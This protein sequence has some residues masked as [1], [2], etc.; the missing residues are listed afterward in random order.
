MPDYVP[1]TTPGA[2]PVQPV[3]PVPVPVAAGTPVVPVQPVAVQQPVVVEQPP[4]S[5]LYLHIVSHSNLFY[6]WPVWAVGY[7]MALLTW[8]HGEKHTI[9]G[10]PEL[11]NANSDLGVIFFLTLLFVI[12]VTNVS[13][14]GLVS[15]LVVTALIL[16][17][18]LLAWFGWWDTVLSWFGHLKVHLNL[19]AYLFFSTVMLVVWALTVFVFDQMTWWRITPGQITRERF[20]GAGSKSYDTDGMVLEKHR[21]D[22]FRNWIIGLGAGDLRIQTWGANRESLDIPNVLFV[23]TKVV[24]IQRMIAM[25]PD[26]FGHAVVK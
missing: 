19:G 25:K 21:Y 17:A 23:G 8:L 2:P 7:L 3:Q 5:P 4:E 15:A 9:G 10:D 1:Q 11:Y 14:R 13:M 22:L 26:E 6:W 12:L 18:V 24:A 20:L 16:A